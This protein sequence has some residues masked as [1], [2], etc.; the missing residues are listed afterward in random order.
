MNRGE[1]NPAVPALRTFFGAER[2]EQERKT[3]LEDLQRRHVSDVTCYR[4]HLIL[5]EVGMHI[6]TVW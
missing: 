2:R 6:V 3:P 4:I 1:G 5:N